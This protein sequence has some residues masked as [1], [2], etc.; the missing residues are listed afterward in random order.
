[1]RFSVFMD[2]QCAFIC[3][4]VGEYFRD[5]CKCQGYLLHGKRSVRTFDFKFHRVFF[6]DSISN[7]IRTSDCEA[8]IQGVNHSG[9]DGHIQH[10]RCCCIKVVRRAF[11]IYKLCRCHHKIFSPNDYLNHP[12]HLFCQYQEDRIGFEHHRY[13]Q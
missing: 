11:P 6:L 10:L 2:K 12:H 7:N 1:M 4:S 8:I 13:H 5:T 3:Y 9:L